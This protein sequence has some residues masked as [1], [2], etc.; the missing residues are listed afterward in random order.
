[1]S[2]VD[3]LTAVLNNLKLN[4]KN[5]KEEKDFTA[6]IITHVQAERKVLAKVLPTLMDMVS[7]LCHAL[8]SS[9]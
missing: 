8:D 7:F 2:S 6:S 5:V 1:M 4:S 9:F 3:K